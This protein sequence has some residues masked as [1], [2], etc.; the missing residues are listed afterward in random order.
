QIVACRI[1]C[2][3]SV[4]TESGERALVFTQVVTIQPDVGNGADCVELQKVATTLR[5]GRRLELQPVPAGALYVVG[6]RGPLRALVTD[7]V[8]RVGHRHLAPVRVIEMRGLDTGQVR[9]L[10]DA[11][12]AGQ[13]HLYADRGIGAS[14]GTGRASCRRSGRRI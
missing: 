4:E 8:P 3:R 14:A 10:P 13:R 2:G 11:P 12:A 9:S 1:D 7:P 5:R 6:L